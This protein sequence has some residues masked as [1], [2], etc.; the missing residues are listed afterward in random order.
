MTVPGK[1]GAMIEERIT[2]R[3]IESE[4]LRLLGRHISRSTLG[5]AHAAWKLRQGLSQEQREKTAKLS[6][7]HFSVAAAGCNSKHKKVDALLS[8]A[9]K[10]LSVED[11]KCE[12]RD[13][14]TDTEPKW[15]QMDCV[16]VEVKANADKIVFYAGS[17]FSLGGICVVADVETV[18]KGLM[19]RGYLKQ[20][21]LSLVGRATV[22]PLVRISRQDLFAESVTTA[23]GE[24]QICTVSEVKAAGSEV[25]VTSSVQADWSDVP[26]EG[27]EM[28][29]VP[30]V[31]WKCCDKERYSLA[32]GNKRRG[33]CRVCGEKV[34]CKVT[35][36]GGK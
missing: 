11:L 20:Q 6:P 28:D 13:K 25:S 29:G 22:N 1:D 14:K 3:L 35:K 5:E 24:Q 4:S 17:R 32:L 9:A 16:H 7:S 30:F 34:R 23:D 26:A 12:L 8:A 10:G 18:L 21:D 19:E 15:R 31:Q 33:V 36:A 2:L 27:V